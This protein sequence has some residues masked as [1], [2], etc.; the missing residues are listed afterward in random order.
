MLKRF[1][2]NNDSWLNKKFQIPDKLIHGYSDESIS[3]SSTSHHKPFSENTERHKRRRTQDLRESNS[4][5][6]LLYA[7]KQKL[8]NNG[9]SDM[10]KILDYL[11]KS[12]DEVK[13]ARA[14]CENQIDIS[15][16]SKE[17]CL[18]ILLSES[19]KITIYKFK[20]NLLKMVQI[21]MY[22]IIIFN[23]QN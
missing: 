22:L 9:S 6:I 17:K 23:K 2:K 4:T 20:R 8:A 12:P 21:I 3:T 13:R 1:E 10:A 11:I 14:F 19:F 7:T 18:A 5:E 16:C 15:L